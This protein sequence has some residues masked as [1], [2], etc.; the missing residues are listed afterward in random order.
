[1]PKR[2]QVPCAP[3]NG[4][5]IG[6]IKTEIDPKTGKLITTPIPCVTCGGTGKV[7]TVQPD[8]GLR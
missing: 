3:C 2:V 5:G 6:R 8:A 1:M 7:W 4:S